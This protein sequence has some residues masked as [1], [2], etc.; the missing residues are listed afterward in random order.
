MNINF[1][2]ILFCALLT[3]GIIALLD[4]LILQKHRKLQNQNKIP[5]IIDYA[6]SFFPILFLVF[7]V[8][9]FAYE[10]W[11][12]P[13]GSLKPTIQP[14]DFILVNKFNY[15]IR[16]PV[17]HT[18][19]IK[20]GE[21]SRGDIVI[22]R[23]PS[24][25]TPPLL[26]KRVIGVPGDHIRYIDK[27]LYINEQKASQLY[28]SSSTDSDDGLAK[29]PVDVKQENLLGISHG[30]YQIPERASYDF[31]VTVPEGKFF[32]M[33]DNRD[34]SADSR[35]WGFL[36]EENIIGQ[37]THVM[38]SFDSFKHP[39]RLERTASKII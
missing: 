9:S 2:L 28:L 3:S 27:V 24:K 8:R 16:L 22:F 20:I 18:K 1:E 39:I 7:S 4:K 34:D 14:G 35:Y 30:I 33:G 37:A 5:V 13:S 10:P 25:D 6:R 11:H 21:P 12:V 29:W 38:A 15:G 32:M 36:P 23:S 26:I 19:I 17:L 31:D